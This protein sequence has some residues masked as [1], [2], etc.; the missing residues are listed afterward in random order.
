[1]DSWGELESKPLLQHI[2]V[3]GVDLMAGDQVVLRP[4]KGSDIMDIALAGKIAT[5]E[6][7]MQDYEDRV[8]IVVTVNDDPGKEF[9]LDRKPGHRFFFS[10]FEI[11]PFTTERPVE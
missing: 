3:A 8:Y 6:S 2:R 1:M 10:P 11:E 4:L 9:G 7:L 5:I